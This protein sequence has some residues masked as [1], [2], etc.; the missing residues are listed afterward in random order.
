MK[1][2]SYSNNNNNYSQAASL[3]NVRSVHTLEGDGKSAIRYGVK[4]L[5]LDG[6]HEIF[7]WLEFEESKKVYTSIVDLLNKA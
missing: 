7:H 5:Y 2:F 3:Q 6:T 4:I 1:Y